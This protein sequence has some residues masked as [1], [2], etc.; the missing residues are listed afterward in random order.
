MFE[1]KYFAYA[2]QE[3]DV[4]N[5]DIKLRIGSKAVVRSI[6]A[7]TYNNQ[8]YIVGYALVNQ[9]VLTSM[10]EVAYKEHFL[11]PRLKEKKLAELSARQKELYEEIEGDNNV[12]FLKA[13]NKAY[14]LAD[15]ADYDQLMFKKM[16]IRT[17]AGAIETDILNT[18]DLDVLEDYEIV[19]EIDNGLQ[20]EF[21]AITV[22]SFLSRFLADEK[23]AI[24]LYMETNKD[25]NKEYQAMLN[26]THVNLTDDVLKGF[27]L[28]LDQEKLLEDVID[29]ANYANRIE[30]LLRPG[31]SF[32]AW[33]PTFS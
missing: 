15:F 31:D 10:P 21:K 16:D 4:N 24:D 6:E 5:Y 7:V 30:E 12:N 22:G 2:T 33:R 18:Y 23:E 25:L 3:T 14:V 9:S 28:T 19:L 1:L 32:S 26:R 17:K 11:V 27:L 20:P 29:S 8:N 13:E